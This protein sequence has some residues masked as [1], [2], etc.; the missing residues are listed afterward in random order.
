MLGHVKHFRCKK[1]DEQCAAFRWS[2]SVWGLA[3]GGLV[4]IADKNLFIDV[5][6]LSQSKAPSTIELFF[7]YR[8]TPRRS[9]FQDL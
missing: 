7:A 4:A 6:S 2:S 3:P 1:D 9:I 8:N 5:A